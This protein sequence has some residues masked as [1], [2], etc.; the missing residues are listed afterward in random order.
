M[1]EFAQNEQSKRFLKA[2]DNLI[3]KQIVNSDADFCRA[4]DYAPQ[5]F[6]QIRKGKRNIT[7][8]LIDSAHKQFGIDVKFIFSGKV[9]PEVDAEVDPDLKTEL[10]DPQQ[11]YQS[12][13]MTIAELK[14]ELEELKAENRAFL[15]AFRAIG[16]GKTGGASDVA[17]KGQKSA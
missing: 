8:E 17:G 6:S 2:L 12:S 11:E 9:D 4:V 10:N 16:E 14:S 7:V 5:S 1:P 3:N 13:A 15:K